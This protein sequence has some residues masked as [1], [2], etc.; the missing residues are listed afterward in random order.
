MYHSGQEGTKNRLNLAIQTRSASCSVRSWL[1][2]NLTR[3]FR[4]RKNRTFG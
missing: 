3:S 2:A 4:P 1:C